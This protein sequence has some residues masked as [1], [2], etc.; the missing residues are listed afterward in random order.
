MVIRIAF[1]YCLVSLAPESTIANGAPT[2]FTDDLQRR[3][4]HFLTT[5]PFSQHAYSTSPGD[6]TGCCAAKSWYRQVS[7]IERPSL[8]QLLAQEI[9]AC[10]SD[11][12][13]KLCLLLKHLLWSREAKSQ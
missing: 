6:L 2:F 13:V 9:E 12:D 4:W 11:D 7:M 1:A 10:E 8:G 3:H 5:M